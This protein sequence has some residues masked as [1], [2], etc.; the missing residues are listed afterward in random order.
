[1]I[2][3]FEKIGLILLYLIT[4]QHNFSEISDDN[5]EYYYVDGKATEDFT[6]R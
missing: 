1:M 5:V 2:S 4:W 6:T 3:K